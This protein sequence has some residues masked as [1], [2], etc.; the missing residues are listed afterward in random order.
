MVR[1]SDHPVHLRR[2]PARELSYCPPATLVKRL[3][4]LTPAEL[5]QMSM[6][7]LG[8]NLWKLHRAKWEVVHTWRKLPAL[9]QRTDME[10]AL[11]ETL[12]ALHAVKRLRD[13]AAQAILQPD[14]DALSR[15]S[16]YD[17]RLALL[18]ASRPTTPTDPYDEPLTDSG[19]EPQEGS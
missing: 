9:H 1:P 19:D 15:M 7:D 8:D 13:E 18:S 2:P 10:K 17:E 11:D 6:R 4:A 14:R 5:G 12:D 3:A 16:P